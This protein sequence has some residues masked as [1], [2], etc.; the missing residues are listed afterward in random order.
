[1]MT[2]CCIH[3]EILTSRSKNSDVATVRIKR[4]CAPAGTVSDACLHQ[5]QKMSLNISVWASPESTNTL[6]RCILD[7]WSGLRLE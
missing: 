4:H 6:Q 3:Y 1:M 2:L 7:E 5:A